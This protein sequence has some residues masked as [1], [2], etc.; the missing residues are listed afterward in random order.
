MCG[1][2]KYS[3]PPHGRKLKIPRGEGGGGGGGGSTAKIYKGKYE[4]KLEI[5]KGYKV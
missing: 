2:R 1:Y 4:A 3:Y 5:P